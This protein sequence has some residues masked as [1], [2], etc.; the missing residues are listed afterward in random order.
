VRMAL[1]P[2]FSQPA[3][4]WTAVLELLHPSIQPTALDVPG[5]LDF[6]ATAAAI[7]ARGGTAVYVGYSMGGRLTL[8]LA[9]DH[10]GLVAG[11]V[12][13]SAS[14]GIADPDERAER[15]A[16]D[17]RLAADVERDGVEA[18]L[19]RWIAQPLFAG[20]SREQAALDDRVAGTSVARL[21]HQLT[22]LGQGRMP[23]AWDRLGE[24]SMP[25]LLVTGGL[26]AKYGEI[27]TAMQ[28]RNPR[29]V[30]SVVPGGHAVPLEQPNA[31][32]ERLEAFVH[33]LRRDAGSG[34][35]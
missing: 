8:Q 3:A 25:V 21:A 29:F 23:S 24:L 2:G 30:H 7:G 13:V 5:G 11:L 33:E 22:V 20:L 9:L 18:F 15:A 12:L 31:L 6:E 27:A 35:E 34:N 32:T 14:P 16:A 17:L 26:D 10:P 19:A 4:A 28:E 1:V